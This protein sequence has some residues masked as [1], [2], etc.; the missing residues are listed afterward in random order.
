[1]VS[2]II[3]SIRLFCDDIVPIVLGVSKVDVI[4]TQVANEKLSRIVTGEF[5][6][7]IQYICDKLTTTIESS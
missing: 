2:V 1:M 4:I 5:S 7:A 6:D 3:Y